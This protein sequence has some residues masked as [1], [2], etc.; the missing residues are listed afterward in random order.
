[1]FQERAERMWQ[2]SLS[3][4]QRP[5]ACSSSSASARRHRAFT[6]VEL[7]VVIGI[8]ALLISLLMPALTRARGA[9]RNVACQNQLKQ[10]G[11]AFFFYARDNSDVAPYSMPNQGIEWYSFGVGQIPKYIKD[12]LPTAG[13][14]PWMYVC[15]DL[16]DIQVAVDASPY[17]GGTYL[18]NA[19]WYSP[20]NLFAVAN[21]RAV[22][23]S[24]VRN[25]AEKVVFT[26]GCGFTLPNI[27][28][29]PPFSPEY[30]IGDYNMN[31]RHGGR[32]DGVKTNILDRRANTVYADGHVSLVIW[33]AASAADSNLIQRMFV[34]PK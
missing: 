25:S 16:S 32:A 26:E 1:V 23:L 12:R 11:L 14:T 5:R 10:L 13:F 8:V 27:V 34:I 3:I 17:F 6:L 9:A 21:Y 24:R 28:G 31:K 30:S 4:F 29:N 7:L 15:P 33:N 2:M 19:F 22:K 18:F 20:D